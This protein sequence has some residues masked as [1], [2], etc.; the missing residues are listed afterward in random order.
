MR[1]TAANNVFFIA[2]ILD[3]WLCQV[4]CCLLFLVNQVDIVFNSLHVHLLQVVAHAS[5][6]TAIAHFQFLSV[7]LIE[8]VFTF[9]LLDHLEVS[10]FHF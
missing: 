2:F 10:A 4:L 3:N 7:S 1:E 6:G 5:H 8:L 9:L